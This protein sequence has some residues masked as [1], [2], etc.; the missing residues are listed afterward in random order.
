MLEHSFFFIGN[1]VSGTL[2][3]DA[4]LFENIYIIFAILAF[5][6]FREKLNVLFKIT[7]FWYLK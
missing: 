2:S 6:G 7:P 3:Y 5:F 4:R 1:N